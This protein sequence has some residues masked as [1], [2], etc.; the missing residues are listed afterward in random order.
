MPA[1]SA[2]S[3]RHLEMNWYTEIEPVLRSLT[4]PADM[5]KPT[6]ERAMPVRVDPDLLLSVR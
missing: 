4:V 6:M 3:C 1:G 5:T 2:E